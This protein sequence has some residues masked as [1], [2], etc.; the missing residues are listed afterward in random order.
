MSYPG[1]RYQCIECGEYFRSWDHET[2][3]PLCGGSLKI[4][5][6]GVNVE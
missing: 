4:D 2:R 5:T 6:L 1:T 3:C